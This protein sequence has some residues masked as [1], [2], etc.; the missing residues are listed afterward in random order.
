M[1]LL[2]LDNIAKC[3]QNLTFKILYE[4]LKTFINNLE[5]TALTSTC[6]YERFYG[7]SGQ[8]P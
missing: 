5:D 8:N 7:K 1:F 6:K 4:T 3:N 2:E